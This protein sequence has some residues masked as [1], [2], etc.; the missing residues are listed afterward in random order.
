[1]TVPRI[2]FALVLLVSG[3]SLTAQAQ[4]T[5]TPAQAQRI[6]TATLLGSAPLLNDPEVQDYVNRVGRWLTLNTPAADQQWRFGV[7]NSPT[8]ASFSAPD[9]SVLLTSGLLE[10]LRNETEL[11]AVLSHEI[12]HVL[13]GHHKLS[14]WASTPLQS[15]QQLLSQTR[16]HYAQ[17]LSASEEHTADRL[18]VTLAARAGYDPYGLPAVLQV[19]QGM[20]PG[21]Q[22]LTLMRAVK[23]LPT[24][25][26]S[27]LLP[28]M[29]V[30][31]R[32]SGG[33]AINS[34]FSATSQGA[35]SS[36][37]SR[38]SAQTARSAQRPQQTAIDHPS[39][40]PNAVVESGSALNLVS[41]IQ[42][43]LAQRGYDAGSQPGLMTPNLE[44]SIMEYQNQHGLPVTGIADAALRNHLMSN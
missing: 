15:R 29:E 18:A 40:E 39:T 43:L 33:Q 44:F 20:P 42:Q 2:F 38:T 10:L 16:Q 11:A 32:F 28:A 22:H 36:T 26:L 23:P 25:R 21:D 3:N 17:G 14:R 13:E 34:S 5:L 37:A 8:I 7:L 30:L 19:L 41:E 4:T 1:M 27:K 24:E 6:V 12:A 31:A 35:A 9:R